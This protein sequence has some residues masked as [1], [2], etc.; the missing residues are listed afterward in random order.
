MS[1]ES[2]FVKYQRMW[3]RGMRGYFGVTQSRL[4]EMVTEEGVPWTRD[5]MASVEIGRRHLRAYEYGALK[6]AERRLF[7]E[8]R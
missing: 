8:A 1:V 3:L 4:A 6:R 5:Q 7:E 2:E